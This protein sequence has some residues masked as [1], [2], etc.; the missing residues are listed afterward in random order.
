METEVK[1]SKFY[2]EIT[3]EY[4]GGKRLTARE[5]AV[6]LYNRGFIP[7]PIR[8]FTAPRI[9]EMQKMGLIDSVGSK[10]DEETKKNVTI[11]QLKED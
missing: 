3:K 6:R 1:R 10:L 2:E 4:R 5:C 8:Q 9:T 11:Y 7:Y